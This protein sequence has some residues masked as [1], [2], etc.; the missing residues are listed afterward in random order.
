MKDLS[1]IYNIVAKALIMYGRFTPNRFMLILN[2]GFAETGYNLPKKDGFWQL[3]YATVVDLLKNVLPNIENKAPYFDLLM[4]ADYYT[5]EKH[6]KFMLSLDKG[7]LSAQIRL[8]DLK[9]RTD[10]EPLPPY[11]NLWQQAKYWKRIYNTIEGA[12]TLEH[13]VSEANVII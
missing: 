8:V 12:G 11:N 4:W 1:F 6:E 7:S 5:K 2:S 10:P 9:Y 13:Y 3:E